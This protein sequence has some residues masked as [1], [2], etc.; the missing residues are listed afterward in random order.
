MPRPALCMRPD[1]VVSRL[2]WKLAAKERH[3]GRAKA[4]MALTHGCCLER[5]PR[6][7]CVGA[8]RVVWR[9]TMAVVDFKVQYGALLVLRFGGGRTLIRCM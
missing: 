9:R 2:H 4:G 7:V 6:G 5:S 8:G 1:G 3:V